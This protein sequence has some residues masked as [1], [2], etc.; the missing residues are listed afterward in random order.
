MRF[1]D[2]RNPADLKER[3]ELSNGFNSPLFGGRGRSGFGGKQPAQDTKKLKKKKQSL[4]ASLA[5]LDDFAQQAPSVL[6]R[7]FNAKKERKRIQKNI[8][9][10]NI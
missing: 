7:A 8:D 1:Y 6:G 3:Q 10:I 4:L 2:P 9:E 5:G